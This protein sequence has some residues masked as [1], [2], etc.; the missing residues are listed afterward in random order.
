MNI[1][2]AR[3]RRGFDSIDG[4]DYET[5]LLGLL[6]PWPFTFGGLAALDRA[7][8]LPHHMKE[9]S[10]RPDSF[11]GSCDRFELASKWRMCAEDLAGL[12]NGPGEESRQSCQ[13]VMS[14][15]I[16]H[17]EERRPPDRREVPHV[18]PGFLERPREGF[19]GFDCVESSF[20]L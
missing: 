7:V 16:V 9:I 15:D 11:E 20:E 12:L 19:V 1:V 13:P 18:V 17:R 3:G 10:G 14:G 5:A 8:M 6:E 4:P 2:L